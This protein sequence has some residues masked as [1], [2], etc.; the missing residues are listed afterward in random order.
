MGNPVKLNTALNYSCAYNCGTC[1]DFKKVNNK[2]TCPQAREEYKEK[3]ITIEDIH[4]SL[5]RGNGKLYKQYEADIIKVGSIIK[6]WNG[7]RPYK[8]TPAVDNNNKPLPCYKAKEK[9]E[10]GMA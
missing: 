1:A 5:F 6:V 4:F 3:T 7:W 10:K 8:D 2:N 9:E